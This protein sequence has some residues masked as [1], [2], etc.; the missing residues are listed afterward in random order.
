MKKSMKY[1]MM[2]MSCYKGEIGKWHIFSIMLILINSCICNF[3]NAQAQTIVT[4]SLKKQQSMQAIAYGN[5]PLWQVTGAISSIKGETLTKS[6]ASNV[7]NTLYGRIP[8]L[9]VQ[10]GSGEPGLDAP[11]LNIRGVNTFGSGRGVFIV[12]DGFPSTETLFEQMTP[13]EIESISLLKDASA[14]AI[15]GN[16]AANGVLL[17]TTKKGSETPLKINLS[18]QYGFQSASRLPD[19]L[20]SYNYA[21]LYNEALS[22]D[23]KAPLYSSSDLTAYKLGND[24]L[25]HPNI[26]WYNQVLRKS[27]PVSDY[28]LSASG[29]NKSIRYF[30]MLNYLNNKGLLKKTE[31][32]SD[33]SKDEDYSRINF[34][35]NIDLNLSKR[36]AAIITLAGTVE[37]KVNPGTSES[38]NSLFNSISS[39]SPNA[40]P[41]YV[42]EGRFGGSSLYSNPLGDIL[43]T[44]YYTSNGRSAQT[45]LKL[46]E[47]LDMI[48]K[49]LSISGS[50]G[51]NTR[52][53]SYS[54]KTRQYTRYSVA[55][56]DVGN[57][58]YT[59]IGQN[60][61]LSGNEKLSS[62][63]R[64]FVLQASLNYNRT[65][66]LQKVEGVL[67]TNYDEYSV[68]EVN[69]PY[70]NMGLGGRLTFTNNE[71]Y[72]GE[73]SFGYNGSDNFPK[74]KRIG[75]FP[76]ISIGW[77]ASNEDFLKGNDMV[78]YLKLRTSYGLTGNQDIGGL[79]YM[80]DQY[81]NWG[82][83]Y[84]TGTSNSSVN[85]YLEG[86]LA[87]TNVTWE[88][89][90][91]LNI[92]IEA[93]LF[94]HFEIELDIFNQNRYDILAKPYSTI[95]SYMGITYPDM[96]VGMSNNKGFEAKIRYNSSQAKDLKYFVEVS[97]WG[98][99]NTITYNAEALQQFS[100]L[101]KSGQSIDQ[102]FLLEAIGFF[103]DQQDIDNSPKQTFTTTVQQGD[104]KYKDQNSDGVIDQND[105]FPI[106]NTTLP[107]LTIGFHSG[108]TYKGF[109]LDMLFQ[110][111]TNRTV[112]LSGNYFEAFQ[113]N[114]QVSSIA[115]GR[116]TTETASSATYPRLSASNN[117]NNFQPS[118]FWQRNG[119]FL[120]LRNLEVGYSLPQQ[121]VKKNQ[122]DK[123]RIFL[124]GTNLFSLD[125]MNG[126]T[127]PETLTGYPALTTLSMGVNIQF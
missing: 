86:S 30:V 106:G 8:G 17:V 14:T 108:I 71:K 69:L 6:F 10:Q 98:A 110:G 52:F 113:N 12:I 29:G 48:T 82:G 15:Y 83:Y 74:G 122:I 80:F 45:S 2:K 3:S 116:W 81:Y 9:T 55:K 120:K 97:A 78:N 44:G 23:G 84:Y 111:V 31:D 1:K 107:E 43:E 77:V 94:K 91:S 11:T 99:K 33:F 35:T 88:K 63:W 126:F 112:Y 60:T 18:A 89:Q 67:M 13:Q 51:F 40:F 28:N 96:N 50:I 47:Q 64:N 85:T 57:L 62:Q 46:V 101:Y 41:V 75:F 25:L 92:G 56:D 24:P 127:D 90:K 118:T 7:A 68:S 103:K 70:K 36:L 5:Q 42:S 123:I 100:Y 27:T 104:L 95:P 34:R 38:T 61:S 59:P 73:F 26:N 16:R 4:D 53:K 20:D 49:G 119:S 115:L 121:F 125:Y 76:A 19:F 32:I 21:L 72:I 93:I 54:I 109:D 37:D 117:L 87:N 102:P 22:N 39:I 65:F 66:G 114:G 124:N 79:R 105:Y 58:Q